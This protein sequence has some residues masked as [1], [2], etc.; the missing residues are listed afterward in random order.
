MDSNI[1]TATITVN[2]VNDAP[3][4]V[5]DAITATEDTSFI[6]LIDL[7]FNDTD[8]DGDALTVT[9]GTFATNQGGSLVLAADGSYTYTPADDNHYAP[10]VLSHT[11]ALA[12]DTLLTGGSSII[13]K[14]CTSCHSADISTEHTVTASSSTAL[15]LDNKVNCIE[16]HISTSPIDSKAQV[17]NSW[18]D[19]KECAD[20]HGSLHNSLG[21]AHDMTTVGCENGCHD[22]SDIAVLHADLHHFSATHDQ[23][24]RAS[25]I[26]VFAVF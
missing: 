25:D 22:T 24:T 13:T 17:T 19:S 18:P 3:V 7:D 20:C 6:S 8:L 9:P 5:N 26:D 12:G 16:C 21:S 4:A 23:G 1:A 14:A 11:A 10:Y 15:T 2:P